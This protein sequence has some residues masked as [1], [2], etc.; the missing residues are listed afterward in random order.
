MGNDAFSDSTGGA[1]D[2]GDS[3]AAEISG[4]TGVDLYYAGG[5]GGGP[6]DGTAP[7]TTFAGGRSQA[8]VGPR[9]RALLGGTDG[10]GGP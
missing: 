7:D 3:Q 6:D 4:I 2:G 8:A 9:E 1:G 10:L 5:G